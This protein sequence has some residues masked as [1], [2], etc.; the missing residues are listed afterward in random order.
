MEDREPIGERS[1]NRGRQRSILRG[2]RVRKRCKR[3]LFSDR[4]ARSL[5]SERANDQE[6]ESESEIT[7]LGFQNK[8]RVSMNFF[9]Y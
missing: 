8:G 9:V 3:D 7:A 6:R 1:V 5:S 4:F 2:E